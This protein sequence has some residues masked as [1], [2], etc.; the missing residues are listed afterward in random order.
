MGGL[1][2]VLVILLIFLPGFLG[3]VTS[4][5][6][7]I[8]ILGTMALLPIMGAN[9]NN[10]TMLGLV[11]SIG[12]LVDNSIVISENYARL[13][14]GGM[15]PKEAALH[16][17]YQ[18]WLPLFA[19]V[20]TTIGTFLPMLVTKGIMGQFIR[21]IPIVVTAALTMSLIESFI[22]LPA[23][24]PWT[25]RKQ[26]RLNPNQETERPLGWYDRFRSRFENFMH[27]CLRYRYVVLSSITA[28]LI[29]SILLAIFG[30]RFELFP[31]E[32]VEYYFARYELPREYSLAKSDDYATSLSQ[33]I[34][35]TMGEE[36]VKYVIARNGTQRIGIRDPQEK[37]GEYVG[38]ATIAVPLDRAALLN[39][40][41]MMAKLRS[42]DKKDAINLSF[43]LGGNGPPVGK[44]L[45]VTFRSNN[46]KA[47]REMV[48][49]FKTEVAKIEGVAD[50][51]DDEIR[52]AIEYKVEPK[53]E[54]LSYS[55][56]DVQTL[57][58]A[59]RT[60]L[61]GSIAAELNQDGM[62]FNVRMRF[63][64]NY[65]ENLEAIQ[66]IRIL[67]RV[68][69]LV[70]I[71]Y[72]AKISEVQGPAVRKHYNF[73]RA[74]TVASDVI[75]AK[76]TSVAL[77]T[78][79]QAI[80]NSMT[81]KYPM[82]SYAIGGEQESTKE[83][84]A[85]LVRAM[86]IAIVAIFAILVFLFNSFSFP[87]LILSSIPLGLV[88]VNLAFYL[89]GRPLSFL[90]LIGVVGLAGV[91]VNSAIVLVSYTQDLLKAGIPV[92]QAL[93]QA[94]ADRLRAV[95]VTSLTTVGGLFPTAYSIG[96]HDSI[97]VPMTLALAWGLV[98][99]TLLTIIWVPCGYAIILE[100]N[101]LFLRLIG[102]K[103]L[104]PQAPSPIVD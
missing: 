100:V 11:I 97:L 59:L 77:N 66:N 29:G 69:N 10:I 19:T 30:A 6:L 43:E 104:N 46:A 54:E 13:R 4:L 33:E 24:L 8:A 18:F 98:A 28:I 27:Q 102:S 35:Q 92:Q 62:D 32:E 49:E 26:E 83:S 67:N 80:I 34:R 23:R 101:D 39:P 82:V 75:P 71:T 31:K 90:A 38:M 64:E 50:L 2:L 36:N 22:L 48:D 61:Q 15:S 65:S 1:I 56:L 20:L 96:G 60:A 37:N 12:M 53:F 44:A 47:L 7:P 93:A 74:I 73:V 94:S 84:L 14:Q 45:N 16:A 81:T 85:S 87:F 88:G 70:P 41:E 78:K 76:I 52:G 9:F 25:L 5:S 95:L 58:T 72:I 63:D 42:I 91:V 51:I 21:W 79:A 3:V 55:Q 68:G 86:V 57:G 40:N 89:H 103:R 99:G 17:V